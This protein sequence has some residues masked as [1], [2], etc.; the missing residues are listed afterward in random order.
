V[1]AGRILAVI[2]PRSNTMKLGV[3]KQAL[4]GSLAL[5][6]HVYCYSGG[7]A[8]D[9]AEVLEPLGTKA[10]VSADLSELVSRIANDSR[11]GDHVLVM[12][13][14]GFGGIHEK[15]LKALETRALRK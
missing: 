11:K 9:P 7:L 14:G 3:M 10:A 6:D 4:P 13:N 5:A 8:W 12:S 2:E 1:N 15:L